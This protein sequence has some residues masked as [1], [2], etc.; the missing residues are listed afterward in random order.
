MH[1][2]G[3]LE[4]VDAGNL[5]GFGIGTHGEHVLAEG[6]LVPDE[7]H[8]RHH[9]E[10]VEHIPGHGDVVADLEQGAGDEV[11]VLVRQ[12][13][14]G[15][16]VVA[17]D[18]KEQQ[19]GAV[20]DQL[21]GQGDDEGM[22]AELGHEEAVDR[23]DDGAH[24]H[25][26]QDGHNDG[27]L[28]HVGEHSAADFGA[29]Q[30]GG[31]DG[32]GQAHHAAGGQ[33]G[34]GQDDAAADAQG[35]GQGRGRQ[36]H[37]VDNGA[38]AQELGHLHGGVDNEHHHQDVQGVVEDAVSP[39]PSFILGVHHFVFSSGALQILYRVC[40]GAASLHIFRGQGHNFLLAGVSGVHFASQTA[41]GH[42]QD[43]VTDAQQL[44]HFRRNHQNR[45]ALVG[46]IDD[47]LV[48]F[49]L[50]AH[51]DAAGGLVQEQDLRVG[52]QPAAQNDLLLVAAGQAAD[53]RLLGGRLGAHGVDGPLGVLLHGAF[54]EADAQASVLLQAGNHGVLPDVQDAEDTRGPALLRQQGEAVL[55][56]FPG[57]AVAADLP[58]QLD[59][60]FLAGGDAEDV[61][62]G[63]GPAAAVQTGQSHNLAPAGLEGHVLQK[64]VLGGE[65]FH[66]QIDLAG[67]VGLGRELVAQLAAHHQSDDVVH[68]QLGGGP[69]GHPGAVAHDGDFIGNPLDLGH[70]V[71]N[72][73]NTH[74]AAAEHVD[75]LK[76]VLH[77]LLRQRGGGL[78]KYDDFRVI[79]DSLG[80]FHHLSLGNGHGAHDPVGVH[81]N[82]QLFE[83]LHGVLVHF[84]LVDHGT[85]GGIPS[86]PDVVHDRALQGLVQ[87]LVH[88]GDAIFQGFLTAFEIDL[89]SFQ[90]DA[91]AVLGINAEQ[92]L[93]QRG[94]AGAV[95]SHEG[96]DGAC[97]DR[98]RDMIQCLDAGECLCD[99][100]HLQ[101][102][103]LLHIFHVLLFFRLEMRLRQSAPE[104]P[105]RQQVLPSADE[106][107]A[108]IS[109]NC[110]F[111]KLT[112]LPP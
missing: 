82:A 31:G 70:L 77:L 17:V 102:D 57:V 86:Q 59:H 84:A 75:N 35:D 2:N 20:G 72:I 81:L 38:G 39:E 109:P 68:L 91:A 45:L 19:N 15:L 33:V 41:A 40:H 14:Q 66:L 104:H 108:D 8:D 60:A 43:A 100:R 58:A 76:Q 12:A 55:D 7:P 23:A 103:I 87:L 61:L 78:V 90:V 51:V 96:V 74:S 79:G 13:G 44:G 62:Q 22:Q 1:Q 21:R 71:G 111:G 9:Q 92:A 105:G 4:H 6:G 50:G 95:F 112:Q 10:G 30:Q 97:L 29:L 99:V 53:L 48:N 88:H 63:L 37:D 85:D 47:Q 49:I 28:G 25:D 110:P 26:R 16:A 83:H 34:A 36:G 64:A 65:V 52:Q 93:H 27:H 56:G 101:Q 80:D 106:N 46:Q 98:Q 32:G 11:L 94:F 5:G 69:G 107:P 18:H 24:N 73:D 54:A 67:L 89:F 42:D 3:G